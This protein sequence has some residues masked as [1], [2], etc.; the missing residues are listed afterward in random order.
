MTILLFYEPK[1][2][3]FSELLWPWQESVFHCVLS[4]HFPNLSVSFWNSFSGSNTSRYEVTGQHVRAVRHFHFNLGSTLY[5]TLETCGHALSW[6]III[7]SV[8]IPDHLRSM[9]LRRLSS[10]Q[11]TS[12]LMVI[13]LL[14]NSMN[15]GP[16]MSK[17]TVSIALPAERT[18]LNILEGRW[19]PMFSLHVVSLCSLPSA[20]LVTGVDPLQE[21]GI[22]RDAPY[23]IPFAVQWASSKPIA[24]T[25]SS[26]PTCRAQLP[27]R[28]N[29]IH[30]QKSDNSLLLLNPQILPRDATMSSHTRPCRLNGTHNC[31]HF[32]GAS[33][34]AR[35][36]TRYYIRVPWYL[37]TFSQ[38]HIFN[39]F[40]CYN[41]S[42]PSYIHM[43]ITLKMLNIFQK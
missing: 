22:F 38:S 9:D 10:W 28:F 43:F 5:A 15:I 29:L 30:I 33:A 13:P 1:Y 16:R 25:S 42:Y 27:T 34:H 19:L 26:N 7:L 41:V 12:L 18:A 32:S 2:S 3:M 20:A 35:N 40:N 8:S 39:R 23:A 17:M 36:H 24:R 21:N 37:T 6:S 14:R 4:V 11:Y 31:L